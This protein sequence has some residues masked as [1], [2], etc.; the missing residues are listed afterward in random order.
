MSERTE[1]TGLLLPSPRGAALGGRRSERSPGCGPAGGNRRIRLGVGGRLFAGSSPRRT[2]S[3][4]RRCRRR[5][6][7]RHARHCGAPAFASSPPFARAR[8]ATLDRI[9]AGRLVVAVGPG[10]ELPG[11]HA[12]L[13]AVGVPSD[14]RVSAMLSEIERCKR[15]WSNQE[16]GIELQPTPFRPGGPPVWLGGGGPRMLRL[17]RHDVRWLAPVEPDRRR[18]RGRSSLRT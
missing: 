14:R 11:T 10:A 2:H 16:P 5:D 6:D 12:E 3:P 18:L 15:L 17:T 9:A 4:P 8:P 7:S 13:T 1:K